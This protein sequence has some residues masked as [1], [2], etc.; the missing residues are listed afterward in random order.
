MSDSLDRLR[1]EHGGRADDMG[2]LVR[3][4][5]TP[6]TD[7]AVEA[8]AR[9][10]YALNPHQDQAVDLDYRPPGKPFELT[11]EQICEMG[12]HESMETE[13]KSAI[14]AYRSWLAGEVLR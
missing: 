9:A 13:A 4:L 12:F 8:V 7:E 14:D 2:R 5:V 1:A 3:L 11:Y 6:V 10:L